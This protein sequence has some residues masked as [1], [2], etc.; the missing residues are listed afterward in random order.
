MLSK[1]AFKANVKSE[2][3]PLDPT[4]PELLTNWIHENCDDKQ[5]VQQ[6]TLF[7]IF[8]SAYPA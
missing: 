6:I 7:S 8:N 2:L 3:Y 5:S 4:T 1:S